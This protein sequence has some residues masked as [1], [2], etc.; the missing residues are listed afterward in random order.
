MGTILLVKSKM[1]AMQEVSGAKT[2]IKGMAAMRGDRAYYVKRV[3]KM[4]ID[5][6]MEHRDTTVPISRDWKLHSE[7]RNTVVQ[8]DLM[9]L[10]N[11]DPLHWT[12][13]NKCMS[14]SEILH[15]QH[16]QTLA[17]HD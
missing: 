2:T 7:L 14:L 9:M 4:V 10:A 3:A 11:P 16:R 15:R 1:Y 13:W 8:L 5:T 6:L 12:T 17:L